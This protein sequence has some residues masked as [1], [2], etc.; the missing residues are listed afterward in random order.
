MNIDAVAKGAIVIL[1]VSPWDEPKRLRRQLADVLSFDSDV[2]YVTLPYG[3]R[4]P[5]CNIDR[6]DGSVRVLSLAGPLVPFRLLVRMRLLRRTFE[7][8]VVWRLRYRLSKVGHISAV[9]CFTSNY[10]TVLECFSKVPVIYVAND[11]HALMAGSDAAKETILKN[12]VAT[13]A[14]CNRVVSVSEVIASKL[15]KHGKPVHVMY[16]GHDCKPLALQR[17]ANQDRVNKSVCFFG[18]IDWRIDFEL[19][20]LLLNEGWHVVLIGPVVG[21]AQK[22]DEL[23]VRF[24]NTFEAKPEVEATQVLEQLA[25]Y[26][27][28]IVPYRFRTSEQ[29]E[30]IELPNKI[31]VYFSALRPIVTTWMPNLKLVD[32]GLIY[33]ATTH[34][35]FIACCNQ[36]LREDS[37]EYAA[38]RLQIA[39][40]NTWDSR[41]AALCALIDGSAL[42]LKESV[43]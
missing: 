5:S 36:A 3:F 40:E 39:N 43:V 16:P 21:T 9:F 24:P 1:T 20:G 33:R 25:R 13:I 32:P 19:L 18:Y 11:D 41:R 35:D 31:F 10:P 8:L 29:A 15:I 7:H 27:V 12:E 2:V 17:F 38:H 14:H 26:S 28:L 4:K 30:V 22:V 23:W 6:L 37:I 42:P 34:E